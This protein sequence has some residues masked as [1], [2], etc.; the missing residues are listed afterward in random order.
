MKT[1][2]RNE[3]VQTRFESLEIEWENCQTEKGR[4]EIA[5]KLRH[6]KASARNMGLVFAWPMAWEA[7]A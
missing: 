4:K 6:L 7:I 1:P 2:T 5:E 3:T